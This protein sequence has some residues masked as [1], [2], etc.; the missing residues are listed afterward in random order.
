M[1]WHILK[2]VTAAAV[3]VFTLA[4]CSGTSADAAKEEGPS[5]PALTKTE[6]GELYLKSVCPSNA[7][8]DALDAGLKNEDLDYVVALAARGAEE[9]TLTADSLA[10]KKTVWSETVRSDIDH[11]SKDSAQFALFLEQIAGAES[12]DAVYEISPPEDA[13]PNAGKAIRKALG[14]DSD[15]SESCSDFAPEVLVE[16]WSASGNRI[17]EIGKPNE[18]LAEG[19]K[20]AT[21]VVT[22]VQVDGPCDY[23]GAEASKNG[24]YVTIRLDATTTPIMAGAGFGHLGLNE[25]QAVGEAGANVPDPVTVYCTDYD[26]YLNTLDP[27]MNGTSVIS[28]DVTDPHGKIIIDFSNGSTPGWKYE[29]L[30]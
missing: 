17:L 13:S 4:A 14:L 25:W 19:R 20:A 3:L 26:Q 24:H 10:A 7:Y 22:S 16:G 18:L 11:V 12:I 29:F 23:E 30:Y 28:M 1:N 5:A 15:T 9:M 8:M 2:A 27:D 6:A 21:V